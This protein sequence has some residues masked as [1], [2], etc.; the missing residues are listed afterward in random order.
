M[1]GQQG[2]DDDG[3]VLVREEDYRAFYE[4]RTAN[5]QNLIATW[6]SLFSMDDSQG[7]SLI[8]I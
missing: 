8:H 1:L 3:N 7:L 4:L 5:E 2:V 6:D